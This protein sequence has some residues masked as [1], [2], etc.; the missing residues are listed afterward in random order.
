MRAA[1]LPLVMV[2][3][4]PY[5]GAFIA[6]FTRRRRPAHPLP[7]PDL[8]P[9]LPP[10]ASHALAYVHATEVGGTH[11]AL[12]EAMGYGNCVL[13][14]DTPENREVAGEAALY[15]RADGA[16]DARRRARAAASRPG[17]TPSRCARAAAARAAA[18]YDWEESP[19]ATRRSCG[20]GAAR[21]GA[22]RGRRRATNRR[23]GA[24]RLKSCRSR[25]MLKQQA[26][27]IA[28]AVFLLDLGLVSAAFFAAHAPARPLLPALGLGSPGGLYPL[29]AYLPL[30]PLALAIWSLLL[31]SS[32][33]YRSHRTVPLLD[34]ARA[35]V[36]RLRSAPPSLF[37]LAV[38]ALRLDERLLGSRPHQ[39]LLD[40]AVRRP[41]RPRSCCPRSWRCALTS[42]YVR[43][44]RLQL[45]HGADRRHQR[46]GARDRR[47]DPATA[48]GA[49]ACSASSP[50]AEPRRSRCPTGLCR[51]SA[52]STTCRGCSPRRSSTRSS[53]RSPRSDFDR[54]EDLFLALQEQGILTRFALNFFP[55]TQAERAA[56]GAR[57]RAAPHLLD[58]PDGPF[59]LIFKRALDIALSA[60]LLVARDADARGRGAGDPAHLGR[61]RCSSGRPAAA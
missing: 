20:C 27:L 54:F 43:A 3:G 45:P 19:T 46:R 8:R 14:H 12:V 44:A 7:R 6:S 26:R 59:Q 18:R 1:S 21:G 57:R 60:L 61:A 34:E 55:H 31:W 42:R 37:A 56:R 9:R 39:P 36:A 25:P 22:L 13:V 35:I 47:L 24:A 5:A 4:A 16:G 53:S 23:G 15:F 11:P 41:R 40:R 2:G 17:R 10:A 51:C 28:T 58:R 38:W 29:A 48:T 49:T 33:R 30:L 52:G 32:G 50:T